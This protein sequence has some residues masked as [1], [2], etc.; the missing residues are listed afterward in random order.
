MSWSRIDER[1]VQC[2]IASDGRRKCSRFRL[3]VSHQCQCC[4]TFETL[5]RALLMRLGFRG[6]KLPDRLRDAAQVEVRAPSWSNLT[7]SRG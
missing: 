2:T 3:F 6:V 1:V 7:A 4:R 5:S